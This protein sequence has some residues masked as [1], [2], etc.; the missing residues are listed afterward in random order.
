MAEGLTITGA[1]LLGEPLPIELIN[2]VTLDRGHTR[3]ALAGDIGP[4]AWLRAVAD[5]LPPV[6]GLQADQIEEPSARPVAGELR[7]LRDALRKLAAEATNDPRPS[8]S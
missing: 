3:D 8:S 6:S 2:T 5:R 7:E 1:V 4:T